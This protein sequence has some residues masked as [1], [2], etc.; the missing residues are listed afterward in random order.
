VFLT[1]CNSLFYVSSE[2]KFAR[3]ISKIYGQSVETTAVEVT[4]DQASQ[5]DATINSAYKVD[6]DGNYLIN[7]T[8]KGGFDNGTVTCWVVIKMDANAISGVGKVVIDSNVGQSYISKVTSSYLDSFST[9]YKA[10]TKYSAEDG[11]V[12]TG[13]SRSSNAICNAVNGAISFVKT[14]VLGQS[15]EP[16]TNLFDGFEYLTNINTDNDTTYTVANN[17]VTY[18]VRTKKKLNPNKFIFNI[19]VEKTGDAAT[20]KSFEITT[21]GTTD[22]T[23]YTMYPNISSL[24]VGK[25]AADI[26]AL[27]GTADGSYDGVSNGHGSENSSV[28]ITLHTG[29]T[30]SNYLCLYAGL[31]A[32]ANYDAAISNQGGNS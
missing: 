24:M 17:E 14:A 2:E 1:I 13:A 4:S 11:F 25:S 30:E 31:F 7:A 10:D 16:S 26:L 19:V 3:A 21:D 32:T 9:T 5:G 15:E 22:T 8:G 12:S 27:I 28:D 29:A 6:S 23:E 18:T 20:I